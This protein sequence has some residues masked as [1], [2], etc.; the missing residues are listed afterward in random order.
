MPQREARKDFANVS[1]LGCRRPKK[2]AADRSVE[3]QM[4]HFNARAR[5]TVPGAHARQFA[6]VTVDL[7]AARLVRWPRLKRHLSNAADRRQ[8]FAA[9]AECAEP[10]E[11]IGIGELAGCMTGKGKGKVVRK[12][13]AAVV[14]DADQFCSPLLNVDFD[15][16]ATGI[17]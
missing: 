8:R 16:L 13:T 17:N 1:H 6:A 10:E 12:D 5:S 3:K 2:L 4:P 11:I 9:E 15:A 7:R 14:H